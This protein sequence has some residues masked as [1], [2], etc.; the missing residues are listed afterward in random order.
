[1]GTSRSI[2]IVSAGSRRAILTPFGTTTYRY[3]NRDGFV[4][5]SA[6][7]KPIKSSSPLAIQ[8]RHL[9]FCVS[10]TGRNPLRQGS[11]NREQIIRRKDHFQ[12]SKRLGEVLSM[13]SANNWY[14]V[15]AT[16]QHPGDCNLCQRHTLRLR[17]HPNRFKEF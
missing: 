12:R 15:F 1:M 3:D 7:S 6:S 14:D 8:M 13:T 4:V 17:N 11:F 10:G 5:S 16:R 2:T 9:S